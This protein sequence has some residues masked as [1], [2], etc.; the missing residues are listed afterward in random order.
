MRV[1]LV[2]DDPIIVRLLDVNFRMAGFSVRSA[3]RG[4]EALALARSDPPDA[5]V[6][7]VMMPGMDGLEVCRRMRDVASLA[8]T[9]VIFLTARAG[10]VTDDDLGS[11]DVVPKPFDPDHVVGLVR[12]RVQ[13]RS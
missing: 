10:L 3:T 7:D 8:E 5:I 4:D 9:P 2:D 1:L 6:M 12:T 13:E 11:I